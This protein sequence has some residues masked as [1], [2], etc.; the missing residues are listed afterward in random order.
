MS[1][2]KW[3]IVLVP[4]PFTNL[5]TLKKRPALVLSPQHFNEGP[6]LVIMFITSNISSFGRA[7]DYILQNWKESGLPKPSMIRMKFATIEKLLVLKT[8]GSVHTFNQKSI[9]QKLEQFFD[10]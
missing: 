10:L 5:K 7:G 9:N 8:L 3:D 6:D 2:K 4:F 1:F